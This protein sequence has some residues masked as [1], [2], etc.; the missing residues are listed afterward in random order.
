MKVH[1]PGLCFVVSCLLL[2]LAQGA[3]AAEWV[4]TSD[5]LARLKRGEVVVTSGV[6]KVDDGGSAI[7]AV[8]IAAPVE[9]VFRTL[10][11]CEQALRFVPHLEH[12]KVLEAAD[13]ESWRIVE[14]EMGM[15][16]YL[17]SGRFIFRA[18][19]EPFKV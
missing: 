10:I 9:R 13:D 11:D 14:H 7:A 2:C 3:R 5:E 19:Y 4:A 18:E 6:E 12:C 17:P 1:P 15:S 16:W 8:Q